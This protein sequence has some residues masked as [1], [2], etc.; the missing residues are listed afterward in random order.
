MVLESPIE[1]ADFKTIARIFE[2]CACHSEG[3]KVLQQ[4]LSQ[5][6]FH[7]NRFLQSE[8]DM[9][10]IKYP[11]ATVLLDLTANEQCI[12]KVATLVMQHNILQ[13]VTQELELSF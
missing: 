1:Q 13:I 2:L 12:E 8:N 5:I 6:V 11:A 3:I 9:I 7:C 4:Y 10:T